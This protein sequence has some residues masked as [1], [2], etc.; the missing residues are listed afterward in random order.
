GAGAP[1]GGSAADLV[2]PLSERELEVLRLV[3]AGHSNQA[4]AD[5]L[6]VAI[7]T[8]KKHINN[9]FGKLQVG[10]RTQALARARELDLL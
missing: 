10:S 2:E 7:G 9:I 1:S 3:A 8:V 4:I 5:T 6:I